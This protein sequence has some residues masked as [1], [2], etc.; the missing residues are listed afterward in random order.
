MAMV[1]LR[2]MQSRKDIMNEASHMRNF[3][4]AKRP[5]SCGKLRMFRK[6]NQI[7]GV[8]YSCARGTPGSAIKSAAPG[9]SEIAWLPT[10]A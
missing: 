1:R 4:P 9:G 5:N 7:W 3:F 2:P 6:R 8:P 10:G